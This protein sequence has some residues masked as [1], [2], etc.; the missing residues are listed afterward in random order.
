MKDHEEAVEAFFNQAMLRNPIATAQIFA[1]Y[2]VLT[3]RQLEDRRDNELHAFGPEDDDE[4]VD[5]GGSLTAV[6][7]LR[8]HETALEQH[9]VAR[10]R[11]EPS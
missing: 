3:E 6:A 10:L 5:Q 8:A 2:P 1:K 11:G 9:R 4:A 7:S